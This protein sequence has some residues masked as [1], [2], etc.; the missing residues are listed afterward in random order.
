MLEFL[1]GIAFHPYF[2]P[3]LQI[4]GVVCTIIVVLVNQ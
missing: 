2:I 3:V 1:K 4:V